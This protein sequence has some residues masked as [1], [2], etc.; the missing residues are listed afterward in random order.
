MDQFYEDRAPYVG[1]PC[2]YELWHG[3]CPYHYCAHHHCPF[4][5]KYKPYFPGYGGYHGHGGHREDEDY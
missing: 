1:H 5:H 3:K 2:P 4:H